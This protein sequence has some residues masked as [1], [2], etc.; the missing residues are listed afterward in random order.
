MEVLEDDQAR[1]RELRD[2]G[3]RF[4]WILRSLDGSAAARVAPAQTLRD[5]P[6]DQRLPV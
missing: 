5:R 1:L 4:G 2:R 6:R 3:E